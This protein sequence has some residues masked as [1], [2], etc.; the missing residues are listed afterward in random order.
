MKLLMSALVLTLASAAHAAPAYVIGE[1]TVTDPTKFQT[2]ASQ[3][4]AALK[5]F[6]GVY[7]IRGGNGASL[8]G[9]P[10]APR[11]VMIE[12]PSRAQAEAW[13]KSDAYKAI[14]PIRQASTQSRLF[15]VDGIDPTP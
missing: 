10:P 6:G 4:I 11:V 9:A 2:Y 13:Y 7:R 8:E 1:I 12:F 14:R 3:T 15:I 5:P